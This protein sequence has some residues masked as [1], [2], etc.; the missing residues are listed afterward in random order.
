MFGLLAPV[1]PERAATAATPV[2]TGNRDEAQRTLEGIGLTPEQARIAVD[3]LTASAP[4]QTAAPVER[5]QAEDTA[6]T[7]GTATGW[8]TAT[9][10]LSLLL[11]LFGG[12]MGTR[13][14]RRG[15]RRIEHREAAATTVAEAPPRVLSRQV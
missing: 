12:A 9:V 8:L 13:A 4:S 1:T 15:N 2:L 11:S 6:G 10:L 5:Q 3:R 7:I 14:A